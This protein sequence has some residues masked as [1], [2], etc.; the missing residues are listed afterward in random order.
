MVRCTVSF[1]ALFCSALRL[2]AASGLTIDYPSEGT[3]FPPD[4]SP[5]ILLWHDDTKA[6]S[7]RIDVSFASG[8]APLRFISNGPRLRLGEIDRDCISS[9]N[10]PPTVDASQKTWQPSTSTWSVIKSR[11][12]SAP[13]IITLTGLDQGRAVSSAE[14]HIQTSTDPVGAPIFYRDVPLMPTETGRG[15]IQ[16][17]APY[18]V[19]LVNWR[20]R[21]VSEPES[22]VVMRGLPM[23]ANCHS[24]S[25]NGKYLGM[26]LDGL[27]NNK[28]RYF[29]AEVKPKVVVRAEDVIQWT[30]PQGRLENPIRVGFMSQV[31]PA[32]D[33]VVTTIDTP[34]SRSSNYYVANFTDYRFLQVFFPTRGILAWYSRGT[35]VLRPLPGGDD[36]A[37]VQFGAVWSPDGEY[38]VFARAQAQDPNPSGLEPAKF[39]NDPNEL[40][41]RYNLYRIPF[42]HGRGGRAEPIV[43]ASNNGFSNSFPKL[44][45]DGRWLVYVQSRNGQ[46]M[47]PDSQLYIVPIAGG[48]ARRMRCN[49]P[50]MNSWHSFSPNGRWLVFSSKAR[51]PYTQM[52]LTHLDADGNDT[53]P[54]LIENSTAANRAVNLPEFVN[55]AAGDLRTIGGPALDYYRL[56]DRAVYFEKQR[57]YDES[58]AAWKAVLDVAPT[59][60]EAR[61]RMGMSL[62]LG[63]RKT[64]ALAELQKLPRE[65]P[66]SSPSAAEAREEYR[67]ALVSLQQS[68]RQAALTHLRR[69][70]ALNTDYAEAHQTLAENLAQPAEAL[71]QWRETLRVNPNN[72]TALRRAAWIL[73]TNQALHDGPEALA[74]ANRALLLTGSKDAALFDTL[75]AAYAQND[76]FED[77]IATAR[78]AIA[79]DPTRAQAIERRIEQYKIRRPWR[80]PEH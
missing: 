69:A 73:A 31:S 1:A 59:D 68:D 34:D 71:D 47:R 63:G 45:P 36:P 7:W 15:T 29:L 12:V 58:A 46:L 44:S 30:S 5:P 20:V 49:T 74:L 80:E 35:G 8:A 66:P 6:T 76:R 28:G 21:D 22:R 60:S 38:L 41:I 10:K 79:A 61:R 57:R 40:P 14:V 55:V 62:L 26:D 25:R 27:R 77:A 2:A 18:A 72:A 24:F 39:A 75:A 67:R 53:P 11:S 56:F 43:G 13:A 78:R 52:Y 17:L 42:N 23:C 32:G 64:E 54:V 51:S 48:T 50:L 19:R 33:A 3:L 65:N 4:I 16:P 70:V 37:F 9:T